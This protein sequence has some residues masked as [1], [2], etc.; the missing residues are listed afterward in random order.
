M[1][2]RLT[3]GNGNGRN[4]G[5]VDRIGTKARQYGASTKRA[6]LGYPERREISTQQREHL[7]AFNEIVWAERHG[8]AVDDPDQQKQE[9]LEAFADLQEEKVLSWDGDY[10]Y[11]AAEKWERVD[12][13]L[14]DE[15]DDTRTA[16]RDDIIPQ[17]I[18]EDGVYSGP[19]GA[20]LERIEDYAVDNY[21][22][23]Q[24]VAYRTDDTVRRDLLRA[25]LQDRSDDLSDD[26]IDTIVDQVDDRK[27]EQTA[28]YEK[29]SDVVAYDEHRIETLLEPVEDHTKELMTDWLIPAYVNE[30]AI[31]GEDRE[32]RV[33]RLVDTYE[34]HSYEDLQA[35][36]DRDVYR[37]LLRA[38]IT[39]EY[40]ADLSEED[41]NELI[42]YAD[43]LRTDPSAADD[44][45]PPDEEPD[46]A[47]L[48]DG[49]GA[50]P[51]TGAAD[52]Q[53]MSPDAV[54]ATDLP[55]QYVEDGYTVTDRFITTA[56]NE[57]RKLETG[58]DT[59]YLKNGAPT[60]PQS[61]AGAAAHKLP[62]A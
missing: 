26:D 47:V 28:S 50:V 62:G 55:D 43:N 22:D 27:Q 49:G 30:T 21:D 42:V 14:E 8:F 52:T 13:L 34:T 23:A 9:H 46:D 40:E 37:K 16:I 6:V 7:D 2:G 33:D 11:L 36:Q 5:I 41:R 58:D 18:E 48:T 56:Y 32:T 29:S 54:V 53:P 45:A 59:L 61:Y 35:A 12:A 24:T 25:E 51:R 60:S 4:A 3:S 15:P 20:W 17:Y 19:R 1:L 38:V 44:I 57:Y 39:E 31:F 10:P